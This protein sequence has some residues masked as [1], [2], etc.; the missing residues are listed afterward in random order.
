[1]VDTFCFAWDFAPPPP[2]PHE[3]N[4]SYTPAIDYALLY[5]SGR[6]QAPAAHIFSSIHFMLALDLI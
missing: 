4:H 3:E 1:M 6:W 5:I 2:P